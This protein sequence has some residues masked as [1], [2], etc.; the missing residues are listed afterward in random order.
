[1]LTLWPIDPTW[2]PPGFQSL[3]VQS[4]RSKKELSIGPSFLFGDSEDPGRFILVA[5]YVL[6]LYKSP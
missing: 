1:M 2:D 3:F 4:N 5:V 6:D